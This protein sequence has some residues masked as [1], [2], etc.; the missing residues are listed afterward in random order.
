M[1]VA[2]L[3]CLANDTHPLVIVHL[4]PSSRESLAIF[5]PEPVQVQSPLLNLIE[6]VDN[7]ANIP[8][9]KIQT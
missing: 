6:L 3:L 1:A 5:C 8:F 2:R 7:L 4:H 9:K